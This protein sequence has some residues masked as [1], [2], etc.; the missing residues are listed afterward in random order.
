MEQC[1]AAAFVTQ[2]IIRRQ[3]YVVGFD[4]GMVSL[5]ENPARDIFGCSWEL[6]D[7][8]ISIYN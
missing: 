2:E 8:T 5:A 4:D 7:L 1:H 3:A 6:I